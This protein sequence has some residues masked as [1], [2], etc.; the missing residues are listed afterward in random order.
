MNHTL[1]A[2]ILLLA[3]YYPVA[4]WLFFSKKKEHTE[5]EKKEVPVALKPEKIPADSFMS[6]KRVDISTIKTDSTA[7]SDMEIQALYERFA[8]KPRQAPAPVISSVEESSPYEGQSIL[9]DD[10]AGETFSYESDEESLS[11]DLPMDGNEESSSLDLPVNGDFDQ[12][13]STVTAFDT[14]DLHLSSGDFSDD[15]LPAVTSPEEALFTDPILPK[16]GKLKLKGMNLD[17]IKALGDLDLAPIEQREISKKPLV[18]KP[19]I[20]S[21]LKKIGDS[22]PS[23]SSE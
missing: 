21:R 1:L 5:G 20:E 17:K 8:K 7:T 4:Y 14:Q 12:A 13:S 19:L 16:K 3:I 23:D 2:I 11:L 15:S 9:I 18:K 22:K 6:R 10:T